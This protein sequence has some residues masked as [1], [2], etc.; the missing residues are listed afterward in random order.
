MLIISISI[1]AIIMFKVLWV[2]LKT[3]N[4]NNLAKEEKEILQRARYVCSKVATSPSELMDVMPKFLPSQ[5]QGEWA[6]YSCSMTCKALANIASL[7]P[8]YKDSIQKKI[9]SIIDI[10]LSEEISAYDRDKWFEDPIEGLDGNRS[11]IS[12]YSHLAWMI[13]E[14]KNI[15]D[16]T[17]YDNLYHSLCEAMDRRIRNSSILIVPTYPGESIYIPDVLVAIVALHIYNRLY[18]HHYKNTVDAWILKAKTEWIDVETGLLASCLSERGDILAI[19]GSY[20][21][22]N[23][24]YLSLIDMDFAKQQ[25]QCLIKYYKQPS[26]L[27]GLKELYNGKKIWFKFDVDAGFILFNRSA[28]G[29]AFVIGCATLFDDN[30]YRKQLLKTAEIFGSSITWK[31][32]THYLMSHFALVGEA[33]VLAMR[34]SIKQPMELWLLGK[35]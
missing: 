1:L 31:G 2:I 14:Y 15:Y 29:T 4:H 10:A 33:T 19:R 22:L 6:I 23:C 20:S 28:S 25:Y 11:H 18:S 8:K 12:Y 7:Y 3:H 32:K 5:F 30:K 27:T 35:N 26:P 9:T 21:A 17:K 13:G 24:Y 16:D 34:T